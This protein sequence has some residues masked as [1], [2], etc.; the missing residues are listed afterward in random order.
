[1]DAWHTVLLG[2]QVQ[3]AVVGKGLDGQPRAVQVHLL[4]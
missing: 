1:M 3:V 2:A 4:Q